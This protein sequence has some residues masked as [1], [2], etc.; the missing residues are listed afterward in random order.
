MLP[1]ATAAS[2]H[3][4]AP[5]WWWRSVKAMASSPVEPRTT[6]VAAAATAGAA[7]KIRVR[8]RPA[9]RCR[10]LCRPRARGR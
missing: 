4:T 2:T 5:G 1:A 10:P 8:G 7:G 6:P 9:R 3:A